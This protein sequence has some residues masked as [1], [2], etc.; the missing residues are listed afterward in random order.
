M[1]SVRDA[2][3][4]IVKIEWVLNWLTFVFT[5]FGSHVLITIKLIKDTP[6]F[7]KGLELPLAL[8]GM[9]AMN[10][11]NI[12]LGIDLFGAYR[13]EKNSQQNYHNHGE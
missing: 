9:A 8:F 11:L 10:L 13:R 4:K 5:R 1:A 6:K 7:G 2:N 12:F 3:S